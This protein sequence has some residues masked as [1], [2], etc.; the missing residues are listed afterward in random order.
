MSLMESRLATRIL[1]PTARF[2]GSSDPQVS[3]WLNIKVSDR[4]LGHILIRD[5]PH[6]VPASTFVL[7]S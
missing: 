5:E 2:P 7:I 1:R 3:T 4:V 6:R